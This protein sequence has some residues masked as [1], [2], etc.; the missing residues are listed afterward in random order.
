MPKVHAAHD[1][2]AASSLELARA[3]DAGAGLSTAAIARELRATLTVLAEGA[4]D[5]ND[6]IAELVAQ[7]SAPV[8]DVQAA[9]AADLR[10]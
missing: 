7:L 3:L 4:N 6:V 8:G 1:A 2:L 9:G 10:S 5:S